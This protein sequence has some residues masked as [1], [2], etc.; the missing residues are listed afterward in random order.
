LMGS[1][2]NNLIN[3]LAAQA[4]NKGIPVNIGDSVHLQVL[5]AGN[6]LK[7]SLK[8][9]LRESANNLKAQATELVKNKIDTIKNTVRDS[10]N[11]IKNNAVNSLKNELKNQL[12]GKKD[13]TQ[14]GS[15]KPLENVGR[16]AGEAA[17]NTLNSLFGKKKSNAADTTKH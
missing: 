6:I 5:M 13:S 16:Q 15:G 12:S 14:T 11:Q 9:D 3:G 10:V 7:P 4:Q 1:A 8:T 17:K 2:G